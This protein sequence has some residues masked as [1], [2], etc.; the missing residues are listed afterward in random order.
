ML[1]EDS[2]PLR[3]L[4]RDADGY[5]DTVRRPP[6]ETRRS[7]RST[8]RARC[9]CVEISC[10]TCLL[11]PKVP[12]VPAEGFVTDTSTGG[13]LDDI[14]RN[15]SQTKLKIRLPRAHQHQ[16][17]FFLRLS[18]APSPRAPKASRAPCSAAGDLGVRNLVM[19]H[20]HQSAGAGVSF[21]LH[22]RASSS[23]QAALSSHQ[24]STTHPRSTSS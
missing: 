15:A 11:S 23:D 22:W 9:C 2:K 13:V 5:R 21:T 7:C 24:E 3:A 18:W 20:F 17:G 4:T 14:A 12:S 8:S 1:E 16:H 19:F 6:M 10:V